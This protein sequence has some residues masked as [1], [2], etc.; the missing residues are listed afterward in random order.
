MAQL[1]RLLLLLS[2]LW[3]TAPVHP[4]MLRAMGAGRGPLRG[5]PPRDRVRY[6]A[7][8][9]P[10]G[11][12]SCKAGQ[13][14]CFDAERSIPAAHINDGYCDCG[15]GSDEPS[16]GAC[17]GVGR[18]FCA[19]RGHSPRFIPSSRV[20]DGICD[21][22]DGSDERSATS[23]CPNECAAQAAHQRFD[24]APDEDEAASPVRAAQAQLNTARRRQAAEELAVLLKDLEATQE[25]FDRGRAKFG[26]V[27]AATPAPATLPEASASEEAA[28]NEGGRRLQ[29]SA[30]GTVE[31]DA[32][33]P[34]IQRMVAR[35]GR[36][37]G[38]AP[39]DLRFKAGDII[40]VDSKDGDIWWRGH[41]EGRDDE[42]GRFPS[43]LVVAV[44]EGG[45][46]PKRRPQLDP[47]AV[48]KELGGNAVPPRPMPSA[49]GVPVVQQLPNMKLNDQQIEAS[50]QAEY[51]GISKQRMATED[52]VAAL[53]T[54]LSFS[55][56]WLHMFG[57]CLEYSGASSFEYRVCV[58]DRIDRAP[59]DR[60]AKPV[61]WQL[62][63]T[64]DNSDAWREGE[65][66]DEAEAP[67]V[68]RARVM[69]FGHPGPQLE[70]CASGESAETEVSFRCGAHDG[71]RSVVSVRPCRYRAIVSTPLACT[72]S[73]PPQS[74]DDDTTELAKGDGKGERKGGVETG[75]VGS[76][77]VGTS[78]GRLSSFG[79]PASAPLEGTIGR[80]E[81]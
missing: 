62:F 36:P 75:D 16:T 63:G 22:C 54:L 9:Q 17:A 34:M 4:G 42:I 21:C 14:Q 64:F 66:Q 71:L 44:D 77:E 12:F 79:S 27:K 53:R 6:P 20:G 78:H 74:A 51:T 3:H 76:G 25:K 61:E 13:F 10:C 81:L 80:E 28:E 38:G 65:G 68:L 49:D 56:R 1:L 39:E 57:R 60:G 31:D 2:T 43:N 48:I 35:K 40:V 23:R 15:D 67:E 69:R 5:V 30:E 32:A 29:P 55:Q 73:E 26:P 50:L 41:V 8:G 47:N 33:G 45:A 72:V 59:K 52:R 37:F 58:F 46:V 24:A 70:E 18:F 7:V 11:D 19:N